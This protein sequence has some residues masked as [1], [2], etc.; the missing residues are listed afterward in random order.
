MWFV[1]I[2]QKKPFIFQT[3]MWL[4]NQSSKYIIKA[5]NCRGLR[6][7]YK[8]IMKA[9]EKSVKKDFNHSSQLEDHT[10]AALSWSEN[11][12]KKK[13]PLMKTTWKKNGRGAIICETP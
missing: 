2:K 5:A 11:T 4:H 8:G 1:Y 12:E 10:K 3:K 7:A 9:S 6:Y 13:H